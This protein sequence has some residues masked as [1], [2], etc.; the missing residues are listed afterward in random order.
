MKLFVIGTMILFAQFAFAGQ[1]NE[2]YEQYA[3]QYATQKLTGAKNLAEALPA[4]YQVG[5]KDQQKIKEV[6]T[7]DLA[8]S[9]LKVVAKDRVV[10]LSSGNEKVEIEFVDSLNGIYKVNGYEANLAKFKSLS[11]KVNYLERVLS[12]KGAMQFNQILLKSILG[13]DAKAFVPLL[14]WGGVALASWGTAAYQAC[15]TELI[16]K[17]EEAKIHSSI[18]SFARFVELNG[19]TSDYSVDINCRGSGTMR[20]RDGNGDVIYD[21]NSTSS[22]ETNRETG[23][24]SYTTL[25][26]EVRGCCAVNRNKCEKAVREYFKNL[27]KDVN[28]NT[29]TG[30][31]RGVN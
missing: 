8:W 20:I 24:S 9:T 10:T 6:A 25:A 11:D 30:S 22:T 18:G 23:N 7:G 26:M 13:Q 3:A 31:A 29:G 4:T 16:C 14:I 28:G 21:T 12:R 19:T 1:G 5:A 15:K 17:N 27:R 2:K